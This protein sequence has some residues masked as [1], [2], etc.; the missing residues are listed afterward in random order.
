MSRIV[1]GKEDLDLIIERRMICSSCPYMSLNAVNGFEIN[2]QK[3]TYKTDRDDDHCIH[4]GCPVITRTASLKKNCGLDNYNYENK[5]DIE[6]KWKA[7]KTYFK[8][9]IIKR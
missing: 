8:N 5:T 6:L 9:F 3:H 4:C 7:K 1:S 2:G